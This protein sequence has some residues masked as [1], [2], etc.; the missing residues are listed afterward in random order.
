MGKK[1]GP[2]IDRIVQF[3]DTS[4]C[5]G[6][7][8][9]QVSC[10]QWHSLPAEETTFNGSYT[11][12]PDVSGTTLTRIGFTEYAAD[13]KFLFLMY[14]K[15]CLHCTTCNCAKYCPDGIITTSEGF[16]VFTDLCTPDNLIK[17]K[18]S[19]AEKIAAFIAACPYGIPRYD[20][21]KFVKC[22]FCFDRF[23]DGANKTSCELTC[24]TGAIIT[25]PDQDMQALARARLDEILPTHPSATLYGKGSVIY[26]LTTAFMDNDLETVDLD[27]LTTETISL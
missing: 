17:L 9:C 19:T 18:G 12:P 1:P 2:S 23:D 13:G 10:K 6:C 8:A 15:Q 5:I 25:G 7:K 27:L 16:V 26:L 3:I 11:N 20:G 22:D 21:T 24:P 4:K 14:K